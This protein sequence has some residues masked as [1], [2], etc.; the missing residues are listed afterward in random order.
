MKF[1]AIF[2]MAV[3]VGL[4]QLA[5]ATICASDNRNGGAQNFNSP[6]EMKEENERGAGE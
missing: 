6:M 3:V 1:I 4:V 2:I 5:N